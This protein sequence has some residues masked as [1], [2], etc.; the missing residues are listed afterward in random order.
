[1]PR[2]DPRLVAIL[3]LFASLSACCFA[4]VL[5][6][7]AARAVTETAQLHA[8]FSPNRLGE[9]TTIRLLLRPR[10]DRRTRPAAA[11]RDRPEDA[12][13]HELHDDA[14]GAGAL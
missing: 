10:Y 2:I 9:P 12:G 6:P 14:A 7:A 4:L 13:G 1:M 11:D 5:G 3:G 8:S